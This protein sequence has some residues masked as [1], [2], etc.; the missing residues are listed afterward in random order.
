[1]NSHLQSIIEKCREK[2]WEEIALASNDSWQERIDKENH[3]SEAR[4][5]YFRPITLQDILLCLWTQ[6]SI[7]WDG[8][9]WRRYPNSFPDLRRDEN[10]DIIIYDLT[11]SPYD[12]E[13]S[14]LEFISKNI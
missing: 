14:V 13:E 4:E 7:D 11:K 8:Y 1:M 12:Q 10:G 9:I 2:L 3:N 5:I 6:F